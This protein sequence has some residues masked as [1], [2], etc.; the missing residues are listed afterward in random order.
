M[1]RVPARHFV[2]FVLSSVLPAE[3][4]R[5]YDSC[6]AKLKTTSVLYDP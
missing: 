2:K 3:R 6:S 1:S 4:V 5:A